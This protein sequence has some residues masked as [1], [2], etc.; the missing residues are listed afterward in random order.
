M[1]PDGAGEQADV[2]REEVGEADTASSDR[3]LPGGPVGREDE[4]VEFALRR[5]HRTERTVEGHH[6]AGVLRLAIGVDEDARVP[7]V[8]CD[9]KSTDARDRLADDEIDEVLVGYTALRTGI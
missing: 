7:S 6:P 9:G 2:R 1:E 4:T 8:G 5:P 3:V